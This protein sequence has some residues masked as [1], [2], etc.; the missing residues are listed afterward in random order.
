MNIKEL[1]RISRL[2]KII[3]FTFLSLLAPITELSTKNI[4]GLV[5][6]MPDF[7]TGNEII[8]I[9]RS[10]DSLDYRKGAV[11]RTYRDKKSFDHLYWTANAIC[12]GGCNPKPFLVGDLKRGILYVDNK[13]TDGTI[14]G[15]L[16]NSSIMIDYF[17]PDCFE[18][19]Y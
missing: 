7:K 16:M 8:S 1:L 18:D 4:E 6:K 9:H 19:W 11:V 17:I 10:D 15:C 13:P 2:S 5:G 14:D 12:G 3:G